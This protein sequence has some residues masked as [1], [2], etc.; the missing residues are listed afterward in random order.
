M[1]KLYRKLRRNRR[2]AVMIVAMIFLSI[3][4]VLSMSM[5]TVS[6]VSAK[7]AS[8]HKQGNRALTSA[9]SGIEVMRYWMDK[10]D[11]PGATAIDERFDEVRNDLASKMFFSG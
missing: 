1:H 5:L 3:F 8:N 7:T 10:V 4:V 11:M 6:S 9:E 2:G